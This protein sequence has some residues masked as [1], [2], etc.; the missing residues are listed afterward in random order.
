[1]LNS[2]RDDFIDTED[3]ASLTIW[4]FNVDYA[5]HS[6]YIRH[7]KQF[8]SRCKCSLPLT[9]EEFRDYIRRPLQLSL[10]FPGEVSDFAA[11]ATKLDG[12]R[13]SIRNYTQPVAYGQ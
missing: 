8:A 13:M 9:S 5:V 12:S 7:A 10:R 2:Q 6:P 3:T 1:M 11:C 4:E